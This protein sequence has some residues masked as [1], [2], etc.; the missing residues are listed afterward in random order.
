MAIALD[1]LSTSVQSA[2][3]CKFTFYRLLPWS[4]D[5]R[6]GFG[7]CPELERLSRKIID[8]S[9]VWDFQ[10]INPSLG[11]I[12]EESDPYLQLKGPH[13]L[14]VWTPRVS[15]I[16]MSNE[17]VGRVMSE[18][19]HDLWDVSR[20]KDYDL[21]LEDV[22]LFLSQRSNSNS[23]IFLWDMTDF[24]ALV[25]A[26]NSEKFMDWIRDIS[27]QCDVSLRGL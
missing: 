20:S 18:F 21:A 4:L 1:V 2:G 5:G 27:G 6:L 23:F 25:S 14:S 24:T 19:R 8:Q 10:A 22:L 15:F 9:F 11:S 17:E 13:R 16:G 3:P 26:R 7:G 12:G